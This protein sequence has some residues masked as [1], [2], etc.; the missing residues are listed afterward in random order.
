[1]T[2]AAAHCAAAVLACCPKYLAGAPGN[3]PFHVPSK[4][5]GYTSSVSPPTVCTH[6]ICAGHAHATGARLIPRFCT[7][8]AAGSSWRS[9][10]FSRQVSCAHSKVCPC[11]RA[12]VRACVRT[13]VRARV[14]ACACVRACVRACA[15]TLDRS[16]AL[17]T[18]GTQ[19]RKDLPRR[20]L[21]PGSRA[22]SA[23]ARALV[24]TCACV[25]VCTRACVCGNPLCCTSCMHTLCMRR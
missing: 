21:S 12:C 16:L 18:L 10:R 7:I 2:A 14:C 1:M 6:C 13:C 20:C 25:C 22:Q 17:A 5:A 3:D 4:L 11:M 23:C 24:R 9:R 19:V 8:G 15:C